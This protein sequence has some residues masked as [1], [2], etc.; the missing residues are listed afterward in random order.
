MTVGC[1]CPTFDSLL[2]LGFRPP[3][4]LLLL[5]R[6]GSLLLGLLPLTQDALVRSN[7][8]RVAPS[9]VK[10]VTA[11]PSHE[12]RVT[13][14][15]RNIVEP[16]LVVLQE[17]QRVQGAHT[18]DEHIPRRERHPRRRLPLGDADDELG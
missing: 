6:L 11:L 14:Q 12:E 5:L 2:A 7:G 10:V 8:E 15:P 1:F 3:C 4:C 13:L 17:S 9:P 18:G 16:S